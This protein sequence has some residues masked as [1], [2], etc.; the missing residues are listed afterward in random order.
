[1]AAGSDGWGAE[2]DE[3]RKCHL[4]RRERSSNENTR[5]KEIEIR[6]QKREVIMLRGDS[7]VGRLSEKERRQIEI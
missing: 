5:R 3:L 6:G 7:V 4:L 2:E 1:M